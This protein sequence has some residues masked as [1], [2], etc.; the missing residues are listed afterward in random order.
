M[1]PILPILAAIVVAQWLLFAL[2]SIASRSPIP[3]GAKIRP[4]EKRLLVSSGILALGWLIV[5]GSP[6]MPRTHTVQADVTS[7]TVV[8]GSCSTIEPGMTAETVAAKVGQPDEKK[9]EEEIRGPGAVTW[10]YR[11]SRCAVHLFEGKV[12]AID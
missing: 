12:E 2:M 10:I 6:L 4:S 5:F 8:H 7:S 3:K 1:M 9:P 11:D